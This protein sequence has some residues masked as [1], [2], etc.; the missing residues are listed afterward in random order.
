MA[1]D[2]VILKQYAFKN[3]NS[4]ISPVATLPLYDLLLYAHRENVLSGNKEPQVWPSVI[5]IVIISQPIWGR[6]TIFCFKVILHM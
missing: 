3:Q 4:Q 5:I 2:D 6:S 1:D